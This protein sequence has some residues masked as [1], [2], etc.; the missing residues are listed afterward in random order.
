M[1]VVAISDF[2][3]D[4]DQ[5]KLPEGDLLAIAGDWTDRGTISSVSRFH[6]WLSEQ[7]KKF[8]HVVYIAGNHDFL[9]QKDPVLFKSMIPEGCIYL[10][11]SYVELDG[12]KIWGSP[13]TPEFYNWAF[14]GTKE[15]LKRI[16][17]QIPEDLDLL[18]THGPPL[19]ILDYVV[20]SRLHVGCQS[21]AN[22][23]LEKKPKNHIFGH[24]HC[25]YGSYKGMHTSYYNVSMMSEEYEIVNK[26]TIFEI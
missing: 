17:S 7:Q 13:W 19:H 8:A 3:E 11:N 14:N 18:I 23:V 6:V 4:Y 12:K 16:F 24:I 10:E 26:P 22:I 25:A 2:H 15:Q 5:I 20:H 1:R 21:L 9:P